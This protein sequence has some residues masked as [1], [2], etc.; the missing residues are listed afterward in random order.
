MNVALPIILGFIA[1]ALGFLPLMGAVYAV[2]YVTSTS[3]F[4]HASILLLSILG[5]TIV[6]AGAVII[7]ALLSRDNL[8]PFVGGAAAGLIITAIAFGVRKVILNK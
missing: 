6:L 1:G 4:S 5:S 8:L 3:N 2:R 7:C